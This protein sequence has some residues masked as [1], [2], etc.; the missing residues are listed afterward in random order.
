MPLGQFDAIHFSGRHILIQEGHFFPEYRCSQ[1]RG[2]GNGLDGW[3][4]IYPWN[5]QMSKPMMME[6]V[7]WSQIY[8]EIVHPGQW[9]KGTKELNASKIYS[10][11]VIKLV[12]N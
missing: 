12:T 4:T 3:C 1:W 10:N 11:E 5:V 8:L 9:G 2:K 7:G 6:F